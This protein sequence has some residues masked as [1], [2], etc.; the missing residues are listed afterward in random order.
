MVHGSERNW[1]A[2]NAVQQSLNMH[3][4]TAQM[5]TGRQHQPQC[6]TAPPPDKPWTFEYVAALFTDGGF[7]T[8]ADMHNREV[9]E[10]KRRS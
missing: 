3:N 2:V 1:I 8:I 4:A 9:K 6:E 7:R 5:V 10:R